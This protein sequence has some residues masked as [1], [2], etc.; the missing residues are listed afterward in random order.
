MICLNLQIHLWDVFMLGAKSK[1]I[2]VKWKDIAEELKLQD[3]MLEG[4]M[5]RNIQF[6]FLKVYYLVDILSKVVFCNLRVHLQQQL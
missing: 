4:N 1:E 3:K 6:S 5:T 2:H